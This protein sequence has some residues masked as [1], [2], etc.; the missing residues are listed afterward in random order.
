M[1]APLASLPIRLRL[2]LWYTLVLGLIL[3]LLSVFI[4]S[5]VRR[6]LIS[7]TDSALELAASQTLLVVVDDNGRLGLSADSM[8]A[9][10]GLPDDLGIRLIDQSGDVIFLDPHDTLPIVLE[11]SQ[12]AQTVT[13]D[14]DQWRIYTRPLAVGK[15]AGYVQVARELEPILLT[16]TALRLQLLIGLPLALVLAAL[17]GYILAGRALAPVDRITRTAATMSAGDLSRRIR[18]DGPD[19][20]IGRLAH[21]FDSMLERLSAAFLRERRFIGDAAHELRTPLTA[22]KGQVEVALSRDRSAVDYRR[23]LVDVGASVERLVTLSNDLLLV[24]RLDQGGY[25]LR[26]EPLDPAMLLSAVVDQMIPQAEARAIKLVNE[27]QSGLLTE[28]NVTLLLRLLVNLLDNAIKYSPP[29]GEVVLD[30]VPAAHGVALTIRDSGP[31]IDPSHLPHLFDRF[32]RVELDR[33]R[34][35][36][37]TP[38]GSGLGLAIARE[39]AVLHGGGLTVESGPGQGTTFTLTLPAPSSES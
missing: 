37:T 10:A 39:I 17:G 26:P 7:Q 9:M 3:L 19:D 34:Q 36:K 35:E 6:A 13:F 14:G 4:Y 33:A 11:T 28:G 30:V 16:L 27:S 5:Q 22:M 15:A 1:R 24:S 25:P 2:S 31:G 8:P 21:T 20:E 29:G 12:A 32:Y 23:A 18:Y 38:G